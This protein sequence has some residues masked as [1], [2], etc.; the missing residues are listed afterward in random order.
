MRHDG[1][2]TDSLND[3]TTLTHQ[4]EPATCPEV[5]K[6]KEPVHKHKSRGQLRTLVLEYIVSQGARGATD[7]ECQAGLQLP[8]DSQRPRRIELSE[9]G[10]IKPAG[11]QRETPSG[12]MARV[13][14]AA[15]FAREDRS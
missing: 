8:G 4:D 13:W 5:V 6:P 12:G 2:C 11:K 1:N 15:R 3:Q 10:L 7:L 14:V 9:E